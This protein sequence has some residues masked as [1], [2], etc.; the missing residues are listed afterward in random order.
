MAV[1]TRDD[2]ED[3][4]DLLKTIDDQQA[5]LVVQ[6]ERTVLARLHPGCHAP[7]GVFAKIINSDIIIKAFVAGL[8]G[9]N[10][11]QKDIKGKLTDSQKLAGILADELIKAGADKIIERLKINERD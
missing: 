2:R 5:H 6:A 9:K 3:I 4:I 10:Y 1:Q 8:D 7:I 11:L